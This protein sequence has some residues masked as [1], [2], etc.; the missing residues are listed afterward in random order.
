LGEKAAAVCGRLASLPP[1]ALSETKRI[2]HQRVIDHLS[3][4]LPHARAAEIES[5]ADPVARA[6]LAAALGR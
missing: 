3:R 2:L 1:Q 4:T 6:R 5:F